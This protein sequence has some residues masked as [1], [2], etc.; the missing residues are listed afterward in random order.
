MTF[1]GGLYFF[2]EYV[3]P[4]EIYGFKFGAYHEQISNGF[5]AVGALAF[6]LG[7]INILMV[8]GAR[9][10]FQRSGWEY[11]I[12][13]LIGMC[14]MLAVT[15]YDWRL[16]SR[17][18]GEAQRI[19]DL[20]DFTAQIVKDDTEKTAGVPQLPVRL[21]AL[22][23]AAGTLLPEVREK[24]RML[25]AA[26][27][28]RVKLGE[29]EGAAAAAEAAVT[30]LN[31]HTDGPLPAAQLERLKAAL[32]ELGPKYRDVLSVEYEH[33]TG[34]RLYSLLFD[35]LF[36]ALGSSMFSL[37]GFYI[38]SAAYRAFRIR[39]AE[40]LL[41][42]LSALVVMLGQ[43]PFGV[44]LWDK[45]PRMRLWLL[46]VPNSAAFRGITFGAAIASLIMAF[47]M[48]LSIE[49]TSFVQGSAAQGREADK[50]G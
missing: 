26:H 11:S 47:R 49:S 18:A 25:A 17:V 38:A 33:S 43:I 39:S 23:S 48:W 37:L 22:A 6:G 29:L 12:A 19:S 9:I 10:A 30:D 7:L 16:S 44:W 50:N 42:T 8:H 31:A 2:L 40:S 32:G 20:R 28:E 46:E 15:C 3:L 36:V 41:M 24:G 13:L 21:R 4:E 14:A 1:I 27:G 34:R 35:G 45:L 5:V